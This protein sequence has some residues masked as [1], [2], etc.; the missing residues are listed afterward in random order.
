MA[1]PRTCPG[2]AGAIELAETLQLITGWLS[3]GPSRLAPTRLC[4]YIHI[5]GVNLYPKGSYRLAAARGG[6]RLE[7]AGASWSAT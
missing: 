1:T 3:T 7:S 2:T 5:L 6:R 4:L